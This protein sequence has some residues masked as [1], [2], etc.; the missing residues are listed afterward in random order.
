MLLDARLSA[1]DNGRLWFGHWAH[2]RVAAHVYAAHAFVPESDT[3]TAVVL[4]PGG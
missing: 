3:D 4:I 1:L 2:V